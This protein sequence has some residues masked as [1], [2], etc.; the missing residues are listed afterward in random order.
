MRL[1]F[2]IEGTKR[3]SAKSLNSQWVGDFGLA[4]NVLLVAAAAAS[5][6]QI[7][8]SI[9][10]FSRLFQA[11]LS[12]VS[13]LRRVCT[14]HAIVMRLISP[15]PWAASGL[16]IHRILRFFSLTS[17]ITQNETQSPV[18]SGDCATRPFTGILLTGIIQGRKRLIARLF[19]DC[20]SAP[21]F[22]DQPSHRRLR[23]LPA[24]R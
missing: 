13:I 19:P 20:L 4:D 2:S 23:W 1:V 12:A 10:R 16:I 3:A 6:T 5:L 9:S 15:L 14:K 8:S 21:G 24:R 11:S 18:K 17:K 7:S 22:R